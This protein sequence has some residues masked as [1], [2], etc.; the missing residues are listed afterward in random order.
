VRA[1]LG[2]VGRPYAM[3]HVYRFIL[4]MLTYGL[5]NLRPHTR[6][7][8]EFVCSQLVAWACRRAKATLDPAHAPSASLPA[9]LV[10]HERIER[11]RVFGHDDFVDGLTP[12]PQPVPGEGARPGLE[13]TP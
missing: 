8:R 11:L 6:D 9:D 2:V 3:D 4:D 10:K 1:A 12:A 7:R 5:F 13:T